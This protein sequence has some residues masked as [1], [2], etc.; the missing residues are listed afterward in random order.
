MILEA[1]GV[2]YCENNGGHCGEIPSKAHN[3][4][5]RAKNLHREQ[6]SIVLEVNGE[7]VSSG[8]SEVAT[9][10]DYP[11]NAVISVYLDDPNHASVT[12]TVTDDIGTY[13]LTSQP[14]KFN[15]NIFSPSWRIFL[16]ITFSGR[17]MWSVPNARRWRWG[18]LGHL[19]QKSVK[20]GSAIADYFSGWWTSLPSSQTSYA[21]HVFFFT[22]PSE[23]SGFWNRFFYW[24][25]MCKI[26][27]WK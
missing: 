15:K 10:S 7:I 5:C 18:R 21:L 23:L 9:N 2:V 26:R 24:D 12:C 14:G 3:I 20:G 6:P 27:A 1:D 17:P 8:P 4:T 22:Y 11:K 13:S 25:H 16:C 19:H